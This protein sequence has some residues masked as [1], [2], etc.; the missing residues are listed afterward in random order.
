MPEGV[1]ATGQR[2]RLKAYPPRHSSNR[3]GSVV[4]APWRNPAREQPPLLLT[5]Q[6]R[7]ANDL[8]SAASTPVRFHLECDVRRSHVVPCTCKAWFYIPEELDL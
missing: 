3:A 6:S 1:P 8:L 2:V 4:I 5:A 7:A